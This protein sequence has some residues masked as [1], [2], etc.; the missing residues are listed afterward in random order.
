MKIL[1]LEQIHNLQGTYDAYMMLARE[2]GKDGICNRHYI[3]A[4]NKILARITE[5][6]EI[7]ESKTVEISMEDV[8]KFVA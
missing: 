2:L 7:T 3:I 6:N 4:A 8:I 5:Q 1:S